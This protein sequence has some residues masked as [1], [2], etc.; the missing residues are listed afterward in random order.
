M[1]TIAELQDEKRKGVLVTIGLPC[2]RG[3]TVGEF[4]RSWRALQGLPGDSLVGRWSHFPEEAGSILR[5]ISRGVQDRI[6]LRGGVETARA[7]E[8]MAARIIRH[9]E[10]KVRLGAMACECRWCGSRLPAYVDKERRFCD[11][12][13]RRAYCG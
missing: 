11:A 1:R 6:N 2:G 3:V 4:V 13:C 7:R 12:G 8:P 5:E 10:R 9:L